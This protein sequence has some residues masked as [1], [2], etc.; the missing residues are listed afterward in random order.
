MAAYSVPS[1]SPT[2]YERQSHHIIKGI[3]TK[4]AGGLAIQTLQGTTYQLDEK[5]A[6]RHGHV[7][8]TA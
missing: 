4:A 7:S 5:Q 2:V 1:S 3:V 8:F 6:K